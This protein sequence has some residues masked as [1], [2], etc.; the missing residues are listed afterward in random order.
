M[1]TYRSFGTD[2][3][4]REVFEYTLADADGAYVKVINLGASVTE[5]V[6]PDKD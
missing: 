5:I 6:V 4:G 1:I 2:K 3:Q